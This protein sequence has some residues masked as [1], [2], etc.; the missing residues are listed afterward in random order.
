MHSPCQCH[1]YRCNFHSTLMESDWNWWKWNCPR[2]IYG[3][4]TL[5]FYQLRLLSSCFQ[6]STGQ[7][8]S[9]LEVSMVFDFPIRELSTRNIILGQLH[10]QKSIHSES[11]TCYRH[12]LSATACPTSALPLAHEYSW[13]FLGAALLLNFFSI[14]MKIDICVWLIT[15][16]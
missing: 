14:E 2:K 6:P 1:F 13:R 4:F 16:F 9:Q 8:P 15:I 12:T 7:P 5:P 11:F 3:K 10:S